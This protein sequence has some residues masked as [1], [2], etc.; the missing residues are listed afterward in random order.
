[1]KRSQML[2]ASVDTVLLSL[3]DL[4]S[5]YQAIQV[6]L[7]GGNAILRKKHQSHSGNPCIH[8]L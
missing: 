4:A 2:L 3:I 1:M 8:G 7:R 5:F 6:V